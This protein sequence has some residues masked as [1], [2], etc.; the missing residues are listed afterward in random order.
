MNIIDISYWL[1]RVTIWTWLNIL[2]K[3]P[4]VRIRSEDQYKSMAFL[5]AFPHL[6][7]NLLDCMDL[8]KDPPSEKF[9][10][11][12]LPPL[13]QVVDA[14]QTKII[15]PGISW[16]I[17][18]VYHGIIMVWRCFLLTSR[19]KRAKSTIFTE[20]IFFF[21]RPVWGSNVRPPYRR[22]VFPS[23][24]NLHRGWCRGW[25]SCF[26]T[27]WRVHQLWVYGWYPLNLQL[28]GYI[29]NQLCVLHRDD[30]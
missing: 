24:Y 8:L 11:D 29:C 22:L 27:I 21:R 20:G 16:I 4:P 3:K 23:G 10:T 17:T 28:M 12:S 25:Q 13:P 30:T 14:W 5:V 6:S 18:Q 9:S 19:W 26:R 15:N 7:H 1:Y 2:K